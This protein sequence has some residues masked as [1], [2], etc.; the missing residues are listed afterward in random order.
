MPA[1][2]GRMRGRVV[3]LFRGMPDWLEAPSLW[4]RRVRRGGGRSGSDF[5]VISDW[6][7]GALC[8]RNA[9]IM[10]GPCL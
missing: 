5:L 2:Y 8:A 9:V 10:L 1:I 6:L 7:L 4:R 3:R